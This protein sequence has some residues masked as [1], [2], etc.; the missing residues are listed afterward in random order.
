VYQTI[1]SFIFLWNAE[2]L[3]NSL[4]RF[5]TIIDQDEYRMEPHY[6]DLALTVLY[7]E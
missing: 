5:A 1:G 2:L 6:L 4:S 3:P 7:E